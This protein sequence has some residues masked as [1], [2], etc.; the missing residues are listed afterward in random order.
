MIRPRGL[1]AVLTLFGLL[2]VS[3]APASAECAWVLWEKKEDY[4]AVRSHL[5]SSWTILKAYEKLAECRADDA[6]LQTGETAWVPY[7]DKSKID[8]GF[9]VRQTDQAGKTIRTITFRAICIPGT[10][11]PRGK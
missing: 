9:Y 11:D 8:G 2:A 4:Y 6:K 3:A 10:L 1:C 5:E 7:K